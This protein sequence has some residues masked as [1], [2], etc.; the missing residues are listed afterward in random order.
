MEFL[1]PENRKI[2]A[3]LRTYEE[4][5]LLIVVNLSR[6]VQC[7]ELDLSRFHGVIPI[8]LFG[9]TP[10]PAVS[11][12]PYL[13]TLGPHSFYWL[14]LSGRPAEGGAAPA[15][16]MRSTI[17]VI[18]VSG[19]W[20]RLLDEDANR[21][22]RTL[23]RFL[24]RR[25][26]LPEEDVVRRAF[27]GDVAQL[28]E[29]EPAIHLVGIEFESRGGQRSTTLVP[30]S[31]ATGQ[32]AENLL[33][34][35]ADFVVARLS[36]DADGVLHD[37]SYDPMFAGALLACFDRSHPISTRNGAILTF[38][39]SASS[40]AT[41]GFDGRALAAPSSAGRAIQYFGQSGEPPGP[42]DLSPH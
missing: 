22:A 31:V 18:H 21:L 14:S 10:F 4:E 2:L 17:P 28:D 16:D 3:F 36:G 39:K 38:Q 23:P 12:R 5:C 15:P 25:W 13:L 27:I 11:S 29:S 33:T 34:Y 1:H 42:E 37:A 7:V 30:L 41:A 20:E 26:P 35:H 8:E 40:C 24:D 6:F 32:A 9:M 19:A